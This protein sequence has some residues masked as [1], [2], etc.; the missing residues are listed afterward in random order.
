MMMGKERKER[1]RAVQ[2]EERNVEMTPSFLRGFLRGG[3][4]NEN[5][6]EQDGGGVGERGVHLSPWIHQE[7]TFR[8]RST[9]RTPAENRQQY[10]T[11]RREYIEPCK[12]R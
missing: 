6:G 12:T 3:T 11:S 4:S 7:Y 2:Q 9:C 10:L 8:H 1:M 5:W